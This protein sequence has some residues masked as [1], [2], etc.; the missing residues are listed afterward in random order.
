MEGMPG[1]S[2]GTVPII[3]MF[4]VTDSGNSVCC[5][6]HGFAPYFYTPAPNGKH[7]TCGAGFSTFSTTTEVRVYIKCW[8]FFSIT[9]E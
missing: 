6:V 8:Y 4:G 1:Q 7:C 3:R 2:N 9:P 5:H